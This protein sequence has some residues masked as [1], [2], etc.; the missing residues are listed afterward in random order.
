MQRGASLVELMVGL[1]MLGIVIAIAVP[2]LHTW[3][4]NAQIRATAEAVLNGVQMARG[5]A[6]RRNSMAK[7]SLTGTSGMADWSVS[8]YDTGNG[9]F[10][11]A[12]QSWSSGQA[13]NA[14]VGTSSVATQDYSVALAAG[15]GVPASVSF[16]ALG[17]V[18]NVGTD[19]TRIDVMDATSS[20]AR[21]LVI[22]ISPYG[23]AR[24]CDPTLANTNPESCTYT[25]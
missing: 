18:V 1:V 11:L 10:D 17:R 9:L 12:V 15:A 24:L 8:A 23:F 5:E 13:K 7:F 19:I 14:R 6:V 20:G 25:G 2:G 16:N 22:I 4:Q 21:R 3:L